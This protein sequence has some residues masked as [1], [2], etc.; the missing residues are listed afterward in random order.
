MKPEMELIKLFIFV[1]S[2]RIRMIFQ[3]HRPR[4]TVFTEV[5]LCLF[6]FKSVQLF[7]F[8]MFPFVPEQRRVWAKVNG[9]LI[10]TQGWPR[11]DL[12]REHAENENRKFKVCW[13]WSIQIG[14]PPAFVN[15]FDGLKMV[16]IER[17]LYSSDG[18]RVKPI[19]WHATINHRHRHHHHGHQT[20]T[21][22]NLMGRV[23]I[24]QD[25]LWRLS[26]WIHNNSI[27]III[28]QVVDDMLKQTWKSTLANL[29]WSHD[30]RKKNLK[31][32][33]K[34]YAS[35]LTRIY[36]QKCFQFNFLVLAFSSERVGIWLPITLPR[37]L[38]LW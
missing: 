4:D 28:S 20:S 16:A 11:L 1:R 33:K 13:V 3:H 29:F 26:T 18:W 19:K 7:A 27:Q 22:L 12:T 6:G 5:R 30:V 37:L 14:L 17:L 38:K 32:L 15:D 34:N 23:T 24:L 21:D 2:P 9:R 8:P 25:H 35:S 10:I 31:S 36:S